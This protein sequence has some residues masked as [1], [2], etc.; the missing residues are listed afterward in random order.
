VSE[1]TGRL[2]S[3]LAPAVQELLGRGDYTTLDVAREE[4]RH[5]A[6]IDLAWTVMNYEQRLF[7]RDVA[8]RIIDAIQVVESS[9]FAEILAAP[10]PRGWYL[11]YEGH[12]CAMDEAA[13]A[14]HLGRSRNALNAA[15]LQL[16]ARRWWLD[17]GDALASLLG[18]LVAVARRE[19]RTLYP[20]STNGQPAAN[21]TIGHFYAGVAVA[22][23][24]ALDTWGPAGMAALTRSPL[25]AAAVGGTSIPIDAQRVAALVGFE[26]V[27]LNSVDA[28][29]SRDGAVALAALASTA[30]SQL[31]RVAR[32]QLELTNPVFGFARLPDNLSGSSSMLPQKRNDF[33]SEQVQGLAQTALAGYVKAVTTC[34]TAPFTNSAAINADVPSAVSAAIHALVTSSGLLALMTDALEFDAARMCEVAAQTFTPAVHVAEQLA[35]LGVPIRVAHRAVGSLVSELEA[36]G[37]TL[38]GVNEVP[39]FP[40]IS[41]TTTPQ[42]AV[43]AIASAGGPS[44]HAIESA[45]ADADRAVCAWR[46]TAQ[47]RAAC[48]VRATAVLDEAIED[49]RNPCGRRSGGR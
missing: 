22:V 10:H 18:V 24:R 4:L 34:T 23:A 8:L 6:V 43:N 3:S 20:V 16:R 35:L 31:A 25:A 17:G 19:A 27:A 30:T 9:D 46:A 37:R 41:I 14:L 39:G 12:L 32:V 21:I 40:G 5:Q 45:R 13:A 7:A 49:I 15:I 38:D 33:L 29:A 26:A 2:A 1:H 48:W 47:G 36:E 42:A 28:V 44:A 11:A